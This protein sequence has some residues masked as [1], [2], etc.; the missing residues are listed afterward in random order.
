MNKL[1]VLLI[2]F[3]LGWNDAH[4]AVDVKSLW[5]STRKKPQGSIKTLWKTSKPA[6]TSKRKRTK[7]PKTTLSQIE[8]S[9]STLEQALVQKEQMN[10]QLEQI[11]K[12]IQRAE[13]ESI[14]ISKVLDR[15][16]KEQKASESRY[17]S[18]KVSID[19]YGGK[20]KKLDTVIKGRNEA[21][22][23]LLSDQFALIAAM[24]AINRPTV[25]SI[26]QREIYDAYK[27]KNNHELANLKSKIDGSRQ[28][29]DALLSRQN[30]IK[31]SIR[32]IREK[33]ELYQ[34]KKVEKTELLT[35]LT[36]KEEEYRTQIKRLMQRQ[37]LL[38]QT[39]AKLNILHKEEIATAKKAEAERRAELK[40]KTAE[41]KRLRKEQD[42][43]VRKAKAEGR[44]VVYKAPK[45]SASTSAGSVKKY[46]SSYQVNNI[47]AYRG[48]RTIS[49][50]PHAKVVKKFG[51]Y[52][53]PIYKIK[54]FNDNVVL[55]SSKRNAKVRNVLNGKVVYVGQNS[56]LGKV[57]IIE[58][59][60][61]LHTIYAALDRISP[62]L[63]NGS[64][65]K[66]GTII[67]RVKRKLIFQA[68]Q[69]SKYINPLRLIRL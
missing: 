22:I 32:T 14:A 38:R 9:Q 12:A 6:K 24:Q 11:A 7:T 16:E 30:K 50:L 65:V 51:T 42:S 41:L 59:G 21:F 20:I 13:L 60:N 2:L 35:Q 61:R 69:N 43:E 44:K 63:K 66:K 58:H 33:R 28:A 54:I 53:D 1:A 4:A 26:V 56:M 45:I 27:T 36:K 52:V 3:G 25:H 8:D 17:Q 49:P 62:M 29:K 67:G 40:H 18:A 64:R 19:K 10:Q 31:K 55:R 48:A 57:V 34:K 39:L 68:T 15:L 47:K 46:G 37:N 5:K 23:R